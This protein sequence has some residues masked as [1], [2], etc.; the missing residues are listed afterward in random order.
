MPQRLSRA[1]DGVPSGA[2]APDAESQRLIGRPNRSRPSH[3]GIGCMNFGWQVDGCRARTIVR[4]AIE[5]GVDFFDTSVSYG[6]GASETMLGTA[7]RDLGCRDNV[8]VAT[9]FGSPAT[10]DAR[11][12][13]VGNSREIVIKHCELSLARLGTDRIDLMQMHHPDPATPFEETLEALETLLRQGKVLRVGLC[14]LQG[15]Q[16]AAAVALAQSRG[17]ITIHSHQV[18]FNLLDRRAEAQA[19]AEARALGI[20][21][22]A[23]APLA[24]GFL[25]GRYRRAEAFPPGSR[26]ALASAANRYEQRFTADVETKLALIDE[27]ARAC[28]VALATLALAWLCRRSDVDRII[29]GPSTAAQVRALTAVEAV[30]LGDESVR[31]LDQIVPPGTFH[32]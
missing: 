3:F 9:K 30:T 8:I 4:E 1:P 5:A 20:A 32:A 19:L 25:S 10:P 27:V 22:L 18:R 2:A 6:R 14:N 23:Y 15:P 26:F 16:L 29:I 21:S 7:L 13:E 24:E 17:D 12:H 11:A 28:G 31:R